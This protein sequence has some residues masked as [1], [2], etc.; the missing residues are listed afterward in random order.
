M[1]WACLWT[2]WWRLLLMNHEQDHESSRLGH[3][4]W[5][6][7]LCR[8][9]FSAFCRYF[10]FLVVRVIISFFELL[11]Q[12]HGRRA[13]GKRC[14]RPAFFVLEAGVVT[15]WPWILNE[16]LWLA[17]FDPNP[18][19]VVS[20]RMMYVLGMIRPAWMLCCLERLY[21]DSTR[22]GCCLARKHSRI[23]EPRII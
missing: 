7:V 16:L 1:F 11:L 12:M 19:P 14:H 8:S 23:I 5:C 6:V 20:A 3:N 10:F 9:C 22:S 4:W 15:P 17:W 13:A 21:D 18:N 2:I